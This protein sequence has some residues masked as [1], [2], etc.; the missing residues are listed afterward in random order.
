M[1]NLIN[2]LGANNLTYYYPKTHTLLHIHIDE[3]LVTQP[4]TIG[5]TQYWIERYSL[6]APDL[7]VNII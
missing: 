7:I 4:L 6:D 3:S 5:R 2:Y 1:R